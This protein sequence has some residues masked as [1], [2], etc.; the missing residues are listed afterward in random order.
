M[1]HKKS[2]WIIIDVADQ[3]KPVNVYLTKGSVLYFCIYEEKNFVNERGKQECTK[4]IRIDQ[5]QN[6]LYKFTNKY[7]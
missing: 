7:C 4:N 5:Q 6:Q 1:I 2:V 3:I